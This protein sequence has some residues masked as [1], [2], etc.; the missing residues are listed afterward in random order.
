[1]DTDRHCNPQRHR[2]ANGG[3]GQSAGDERDSPLPD[4][5]IVHDPCQGEDDAARRYTDLMKF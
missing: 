2:R 1:M 5:V 4:G 3:H